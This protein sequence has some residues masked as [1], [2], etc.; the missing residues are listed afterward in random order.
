MTF[1][2]FVLSIAS[3]NRGNEVEGTLSQHNRTKEQSA[4]QAQNYYRQIL[5][6]S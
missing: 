1:C 3:D 6:A 2:E 5:Y 4:N